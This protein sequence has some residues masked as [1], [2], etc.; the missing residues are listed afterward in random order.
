MIAVLSFSFFLAITN[1][2]AEEEVN[3]RTIEDT[4]NI[5]RTTECS[6]SRICIGY[7]ECEYSSGKKSVVKMICKADSNF[8]C[9]KANDC[10][11]QLLSN[12][13]SIA[14]NKEKNSRGLY[15][16]CPSN[17]RLGKPKD[18]GNDVSNSRFCNT[19]DNTYNSQVIINFTVDRMTDTPK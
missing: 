2:L 14:I 1:V 13:I 19:L 9:P 12:Q 4:L 17:S 7:A 10:I 15:P 8:N 5:V 16:F 11:N 3:C 18:L 6:S